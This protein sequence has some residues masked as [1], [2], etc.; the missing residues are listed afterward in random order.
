MSLLRLPPETLTQIFDQIGSYFFHEDL[1]RLTVCKQ[2]FEFALPAYFKCI[3]FSQET[4]R[5]LIASGVMKRSSP[6]KDS[7]AILDLELKGYQAYNSTSYPQEYGQESNYLEAPT[8]N[9]APGDDPVETWVEVLNNDLA[10]LATIAQQ[11]RRLHTLRI[12]AWSYP[13]P[14]TLD[15]PRDYL[16]LPAMQSLLSL[17]NLRVLV[18]D[19]SVG[20]SY[21]PGEQGT[22]C[23]ICPAIGTLLRTLRTLHLRMR[24]ICPDVLKPRDSNDSLHLSVV[25]VNMSLTRNLPGITSATHSKRCG[26]QTG[27]LLQLIADMR[28]QAEVLSTRMAPP[29][30]VRILTHSLPRFEIKSLDVLT[31]KTMLLDDDMAWDEDGKTVKEDSEPES[32]L[33]DDD[34]SSTFSDE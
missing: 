23:H 29:K 24:S 28:E 34:F 7:L 32:E 30:T 1:G 9:E 5:S 33:L 16:S 17:E 15:S 20:F 8:S 2:W 19:L 10:Q 21:P 27:G 31:G 6:L 18:L 22:G 13:S 4:L 3:T 12:Q 14:E 26:S 25:V 11:S